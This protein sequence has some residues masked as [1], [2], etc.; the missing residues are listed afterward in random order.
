[1]AGSLAVWRRGLVNFADTALV[2]ASLELGALL[3]AFGTLTV[4]RLALT[5]CALTLAVLADSIL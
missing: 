1:M 4:G 2:D 3:T 5:I